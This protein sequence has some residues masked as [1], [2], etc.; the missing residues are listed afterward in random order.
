MAKNVTLMSDNW[1]QPQL[2][3]FTKDATLGQFLI[4]MSLS[5][6]GILAWPNWALC[7]GSHN[8]V[9]KVSPGCLLTCRLYWRNGAQ[10]HSV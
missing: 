8:A 4:C 2:C 10:P 5:V 1:I 3:N 6:L 9:I 7:P